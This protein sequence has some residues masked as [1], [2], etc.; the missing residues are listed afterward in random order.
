M[1]GTRPL[2]EERARLAPQAKVAVGPSGDRYEQ[3]ADRVAVLEGAL[4]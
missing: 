3:E 1:R 2:V 4:G